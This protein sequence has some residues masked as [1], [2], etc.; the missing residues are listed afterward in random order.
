MNKLLPYIEIARPDHWFKNIFLLPGIL[1]YFY[2]HPEALQDFSLLPLLLGLVGACL[3]AS[4]N[5][6]INE[7]LDAPRDAHHPEKKNRP[8]PSGK[9]HIPTAYV[10]WIASGLIGLGVGALVSWGV[11]FSLLALWVAGMAYNIPPVRT[12]DRAYLDVF[13]ESVNNPLRMLIGWYST[14]LG[15]PPPFSALLAYWMF[16]GFLMAMKRMAEYRMI[17][18][19]ERAASYRDSFAY[20]NEERL[21]VSILFYAT[22][23]ALLSG[24][25]IASY[26][27]ELILAA[28]FVAYVMAY[29]LHIGFKENSPVQFPEKLYTQK[30]LVVFVAITFTVCSLL[31][32]VDVDAFRS[33]I[34]PD[35]PPPEPP[36]QVETGSAS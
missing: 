15:A 26:R 31:L 5:Y 19:K 25:F 24:Y 10:W 4:S 28:P 34:T 22:A 18:D 17:Q 12:K 16:G 35:I 13:S 1:L 32:F 3:V 33:L 23:F 30:K 2:F 11:F 6:I 9:V 27:V 7:V 29:Y 14:G 36:L 21:L 20:Y 8:V